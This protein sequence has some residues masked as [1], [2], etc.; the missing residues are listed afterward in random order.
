MLVRKNNF[1]SIIINLQAA[2]KYYITI[3][4]IQLFLYRSEN[5]KK[6]ML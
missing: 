4:V 3:I 6:Q 1:I 5:L 2:T